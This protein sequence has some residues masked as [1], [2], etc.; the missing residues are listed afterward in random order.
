MGSPCGRLAL[1]LAA[2]LWLGGCYPLAANLGPAGMPQPGMALVLASVTQ[3]S[4][5]DPT[6]FHDRALFYFSSHD[7]RHR[8][9][10]ES[11]QIHRPVLGPPNRAL[12]DAGLEAVHGRLYATPVPAGSYRLERF[13]VE[14]PSQQEIALA[15]PI[16]VRVGEGEAVYIG[17]L[18]A[19]FCIRH[20]YAN[21]AGLAGVTLS[22]QDRAARDLPL[23]RARHPSLRQTTITPRVLDD[24][25]LRQQTAPLAEP[26]AC[27]RN[28]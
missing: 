12:A 18:H 23:L 3:S 10:L 16:E 8:F 27:W 28:C 4:D 19:A 15:A 6:P 17:N 20:A 21:Q 5:G 13:K 9:R 22:V 1:S 11:A 2:V 7:G 14:W 25:R 24:A 26:C